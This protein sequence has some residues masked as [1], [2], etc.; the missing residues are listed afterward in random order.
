M[1]KSTT[2]KAIK[3]K[4][5]LLKEL[6]KVRARKSFQQFVTYTYEGYEM[7]WFHK[8]VCAYL[9]AL[10]KGDIKKL[11]IFLPPQHGKSELSSRDVSLLT[12]WVEIRI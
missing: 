6:Y 5:A 3:E 8:C 4:E 11:M 2:L 9:D 10:Y 7:E 1:R 12:C